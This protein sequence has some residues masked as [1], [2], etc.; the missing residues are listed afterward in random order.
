MRDT[1]TKTT[2]AEATH[3]LDS[4]RVPVKEADRIAG[5]YP[6]WGASGVIDHVN[7]YLFDETSLLI[8]EDGENL[9]SR[10]TPIAFL[11]S[12]KYWVNNHAHVLTA[13]SNFDIRFLYYLMLQFPVQEYL[14][15][16]TRP[17]LTAKS[18]KA[19]PIS[20][21]SLA[22]QRRI[23]GVLG[24]LDNLIDTNRRLAEMM[25]TL[26]VS[27]VSSVGGE[28]TLSEVAQLSA[29]RQQRPDNAMVDHYSIPA[30]DT[31]R[32]PDRVNGESIKSGKLRIDEP[33]VL[34]SRL[35]PAT[36]RVW[37]TYPDDDVPALCSTEFVPFV[38]DGDTDPEAVWAACAST[39]FAMQ[40]VAVAT[41]TT[42]SR[43]RVAKDT[44]P[45]LPIPDPQCLDFRQ[46]QAVKYLVRE[47]HASRSAADDAV[48]V[49]DELLP[50][51][52]SGRIRVSEAAELVEGL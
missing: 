43:Q 13:K 35:N 24:A 22:E 47:A 4:R 15:G 6:Y 17:K 32:M 51:L 5:P 11:A 38:S 14:S 28:A 37:M 21:P 50:L 44:I 27:I 49:R 40:M 31:G 19:I 46:R 16:S 8:A 36:P 52:V 9:R 3:S 41:G 10:K 26:A 29:T 34:V 1:W 12:G 7:K 45:N 23:A 2:L 48:G 20:V 25:S 42:G 18:L 33:T 39:E 30:F